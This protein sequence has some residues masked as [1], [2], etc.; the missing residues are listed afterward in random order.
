MDSHHLGL[1]VQWY[2]NHWSWRWKHIALPKRQWKHL[3]APSFKEMD[4]FSL[5]FGAWRMT[6]SY[7]L[8][9]QT[10][11]KENFFHVSKT[12]PWVVFLEGTGFWESLEVVDVPPLIMVCINP[13]SRQK[14]GWFLQ[15]V[16]N[17]SGSSGTLSPRMKS[18]PQLLKLGT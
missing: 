18:N 2:W 15:P 8:S 5:I 6:Q 14:T 16:L 17:K 1:Q 13:R 4:G 12:K 9:F 3:S 10:K 11:E 7:H